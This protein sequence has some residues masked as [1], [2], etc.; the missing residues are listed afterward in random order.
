MRM[1]GDGRSH[2]RRRGQPA[3]FIRHPFLSSQCEGEPRAALS[4]VSYAILV[5]LR[6]RRIELPPLLVAASLFFAEL[7]FLVV[8]I[9]HAHCRAAL[10]DGVLLR[11]GPR[12]PRR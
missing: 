12:A 2:G 3:L 9:R 11:G 10:A 1:E 6:G 7:Q 4:I 8:L 5:V